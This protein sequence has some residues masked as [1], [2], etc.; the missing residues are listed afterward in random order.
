MQ[1]NIY[2]E[3]A[4]SKSN[5][6]S[7][8][9]LIASAN[10]AS[11][12]VID[13]ISKGATN[14]FAEGSINFR[15]VGGS[16]T[17]N[18]IERFA[19]EKAKELFH[20]QYANVQLLSGTMANY[21]VYLALLN[22]GDSVLSM[23]LS[24]GGHLSHGATFNLSGKLYN[25]IHYGTDANEN[26]DYDQIEELAKSHKPKM[27][28][29]GSSSY[30][31]RINVSR[32][33]NIADNC[34]AYLHFDAAHYVG[35]IAAGLYPNPFDQGADTMSFSTY[36]TLRGPRGGCVL[37]TESLAKQIENTIF[38][39]LQSGPNEASILGIAISFEE[40]SQNEFKNYMAH[41]IN[42]AQTMSAELTKLGYKVVTN[43]SDTHL[44]LVDLSRSQSEVGQLS[45]AEVED[46]CRSS[47][48]TLNKNLIPNDKRS[49]KKTSGV[50]IGMQAMTSR[51]IKSAQVI[52]IAE[53][54]DKSIKIPVEQLDAR[55]DL[56]SAIEKLCI[57]YPIV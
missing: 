55:A 36:K 43:G 37:A 5:L 9:R 45:G 41:T 50:R 17:Y 31:R 23:D 28:I 48:I 53:Y 25:F 30:P 26:I 32:L 44:V 54:I 10:Y 57:N 47:N 12:G 51:N 34:G 49:P 52:Q 15:F 16:D 8:L 1:M 4:K 40:A 11:A 2:D 39:G 7:E 22:Q 38:P 3:I 14:I 42:N 46:R 35:L 33:K 56:N 21:A 6:N 24:A 13:A 20:A 27:I 29:A 19:I 18:N